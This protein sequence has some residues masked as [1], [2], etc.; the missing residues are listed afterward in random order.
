L[1]FESPGGVS[2][3]FML[4]GREVWGTIIILE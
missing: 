1:V 3:A 4:V 2:A